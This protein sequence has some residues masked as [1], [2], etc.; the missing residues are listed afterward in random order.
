MVALCFISLFYQF[1]I[2]GDGILDLLFITSRGEGLFYNRDGYQLHV[3]TFQIEPAYV[4]SGWFDSVHTSDHSN[5][6]KNVLQ[7][8]ITAVNLDDSAGMELIVPDKAGNITC[9]DAVTAK[10]KWSTSV[11]GTSFAGSS[12]VDVNL[13]GQLDVVVATS[14]GNVFALNGVTGGVLPKYP[15]HASKGISGNVL[16]TKFNRIRGPYDLVFLSDDGILH[17]LASDHSCESQVALADTSLVDLLL[18]DLSPVTS[19]GAEVL[20]STTDG[21]LVCLGSGEQ[22]PP[23]ELGDGETKVIMQRQAMPGGDYTGRLSLERGVVLIETWMRD[24]KEVT[25]STLDIYFTI[26]SRVRDITI[27]GSTDS[28]SRR[29]NIKKEITFGSPNTAAVTYLTQG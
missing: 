3:Y 14:E 7:M 6:H 8:P 10:I 9:L 24:I 17:I 22:T 21:S 18:H 1:D 19:R 4:K 12:V 23:E 2:D 13:D 16:I 29:Q 28:L 15:Y 27:G 11:G 25:G 26:H 5:I 20:V